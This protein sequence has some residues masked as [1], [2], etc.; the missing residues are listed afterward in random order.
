[1]SAVRR[2]RDAARGG[3]TDRLLVLRSA[4]PE[5][6]HALGE[7]LGHLLGSGDIVLL[8]GD[9][10]AGKTALAQGIARGLGVAGPVSSPTFTIL[11]EYEGRIPLYHFDLYR[12]EDPDELEALGFGDYFYGDGV[13]VV[14]WAERGEGGEGADGGAAWPEDAL[15]IG[16]AAGGPGPEER[17]MRLRAMGPRGE[18]LLAA[19]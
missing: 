17:E 11:K 19:L 12:I 6:T 1:M 4:S 13:S 18:A 8:T 14:E 3:A 2:R 10:G 15:R 5:A 7:R 16:I 9:L